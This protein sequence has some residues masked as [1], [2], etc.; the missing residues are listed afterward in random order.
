MAWREQFMGGK[1]PRHF[2]PLATLNAGGGVE[3]FVSGKIALRGDL[4]YVATIGG[5][6]CNN[7]RYTA[8]AT[9]YMGK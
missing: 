5:F 9:Y 8:D 3:Y 7:F 4:R 2:D 1:D 6:N